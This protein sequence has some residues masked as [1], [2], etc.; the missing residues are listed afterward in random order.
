MGTQD[1]GLAENCLCVCVCVCVCVCARARA[2]MRACSVVFDFVIP[3]TVAHQAPLAFQARILE[4]V[5]ISYSRDLA[6]P[7]IEP[8]SPALAGGFFTTY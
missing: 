6:G 3:R 5:A 8:A 4:W 2:R 1:K 7:G